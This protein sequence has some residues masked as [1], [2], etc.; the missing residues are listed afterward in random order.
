MNKI[1]KDKFLFAAVAVIIIIFSGVTVANQNQTSIVKEKEETADYDEFGI[2][3]IKGTVYTQGLEWGLDFPP[4]TK[5]FEGKAKNLTVKRLADFRNPIQMGDDCEYQCINIRLYRGRPWILPLTR[6]TALYRPTLNF[7][8][9][10]IL[11]AS[12]TQP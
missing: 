5:N 11:S 1:K 2:C 12:K 9:I 3:I 7:W 8:G 6:L 4:L 10:G